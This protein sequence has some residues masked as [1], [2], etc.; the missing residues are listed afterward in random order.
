MVQSS[1]YIQRNRREIHSKVQY[2]PQA[3][4]LGFLDISVKNFRFSAPNYLCFSPSS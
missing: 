3:W 1:N 4:A 2:L